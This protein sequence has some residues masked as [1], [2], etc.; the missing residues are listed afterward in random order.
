MLVHTCVSGCARLRVC[1]KVVRVPICHIRACVPV[2]VWPSIGFMSVSVSV[3]LSVQKHGSTGGGCGPI[4][5]MCVCACVG[6]AQHG[7]HSVSMY[8]CV[9][10]CARV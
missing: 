5:H 7:V 6:V 8:K 2:W 10:E 3:S 4:F 1:C 9:I